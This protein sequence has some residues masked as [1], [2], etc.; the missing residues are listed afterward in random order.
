MIFFGVFVLLNLT[1]DYIYSLKTKEAIEQGIHKNYLK[2]T[3]IH[4]KKNNYDL[5]ILG[6]SRAYTSYNPQVLDSLLGIKSYNMG[7]SAQDIAESYYMLKEILEYQEPKYVVLDLF[8]PSADESHEYYQILSNASFFNDKRIQ[9]DLIS[10]AYGS[11]GPVNY[12]VP[13]IKLKNYIKQDLGNLLGSNNNKKVENQWIRGYL[14]DT[15]TITKKGIEQLTPISNMENTSFNKKRFELYM[16]KIISLLNQKK[17]S[18]LTVRSPYPPSRIEIS[19]NNDEHNYFEKY[20][21]E[22]H[23]PFLDYNTKQHRTNTR[24]FDTDFSDYHHPNFRGAKTAS[25]ILADFIQEQ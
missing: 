19:K 16:G 24:F 6:S 7:T 12:L 3:D 15:A 13:I 14:N 23:I 18:L 2:W 20:T 22:H 21:S 5:I 9:Y 1:V 10:K 8:F 25:I 17:I 11:S 4:L